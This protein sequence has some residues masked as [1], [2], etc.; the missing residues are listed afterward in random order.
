MPLSGCEDGT[1]LGGWEG[2]TVAGIERIDGAVAEVW[3][4]LSPAPLRCFGCDGCGEAV[5]RLHEI[6]DRRVRDPPILDAS[7]RLHVPRRRVACPRCGP[8]L[9]RPSW[10]GR[11]A[12]VT[13]RFA[14]SVARLC[15]G[16]PVQHV[17]AFF[18]LSWTT[19]KRIDNRHLAETLGPVAGGHRL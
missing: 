3:I 8:K 12:R 16:L 17:A 9:A 18:R 1:W 7:T 14:E 6:E 13:T 10:L 5:D 19:L 2:Y 15:R 4:D 11:Y